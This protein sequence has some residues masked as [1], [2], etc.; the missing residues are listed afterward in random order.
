MKSIYISY[1]VI[2]RV[3]QDIRLSLDS[4][5][6][7]RLLDIGCGSGAASACLIDQYP[8]LEEVVLVDSSEY[9]LDITTS[10]LEKSHLGSALSPLSITSYP[11]LLSVVEEVIIGGGMHLERKGS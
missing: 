1:S 2:Y 7:K 8:G 6:P 4:F 11:S 5:D 10:F 9:M 3:L